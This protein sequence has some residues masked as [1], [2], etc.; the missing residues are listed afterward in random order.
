[1]DAEPAPF[2]PGQSPQYHANVDI[3]IVTGLASVA[4]KLADLREEGSVD[5][6]VLFM[7]ERLQK[8]VQSLAIYVGVDVS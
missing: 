3:D 1:M 2:G 5:P 8:T 4:V 6:D 7:I